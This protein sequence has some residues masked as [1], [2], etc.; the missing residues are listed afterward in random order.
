MARESRKIS[1][2][3]QSKNS[4]RVKRGRNQS[5]FARFLRRVTLVVV[6]GLVVGAT[7]SVYWFFSSGKAA[8]IY[9]KLG[10]TTKESVKNIGF[11]L[12]HIVVDGR[13][14]T[15]NKNLIRA[16]NLKQGHYIHDIDLDAVVKNIKKLPWVHSVRI[17]RRLPDTLFVKLVEKQPIGFWQNKGKLY[18]VD[19]HGTI[20]GQ[21]PL[22]E[23]PGYPI[24]TGREAASKLPW[25]VQK[26]GNFESIYAKTTGAVYVSK[27]RWDIVLNNKLVIKLPETGIDEALTRVAEL[28][29][30]NKLMLGDVE[31]IDLRSAGKTY[32]Y[33][34]KK[35]LAKI[36]GADK[37]KHA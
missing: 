4:R 10:Y 25:L 27:R 20:I 6:L 24:V 30:E 17:E 29:S 13:V 9:A 11:R 22:K 33:M 19:T 3:R 37:G 12:D 5:G 14:R 23:Y 1:S 26:L 31:Y 34:S 21:Y 8:S 28:D 7:G 35:G 2:K 36:N 32:F 15:N 18:L 16:I